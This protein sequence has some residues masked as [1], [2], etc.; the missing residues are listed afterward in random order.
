MKKNSLKETH[1][2]KSIADNLSGLLEINNLNSNQLANLLGIPMMTVRRLLSGETEDPRI[3][4]LKIISDYFGVSV[5]V[6]VGNNSQNLLM[7]S[8]KVAS[9]LVP[10]IS[11]DSLSTS[12]NIREIDFKTLTE[13]QSISLNEQDTISKST[14]ALESKPSM[15]PRF[16]NG[17][18]FIIDPE[19]MP[20][21]GDI[22]LVK[23]KLNNNVTLRELV[24]DPPVWQLLALTANSKP[25]DFQESEHEIVG[26]N[27]LTLLYSNKFNG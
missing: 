10:K 3:S 26:V 16:P 6:L 18:I 21:D 14:F 24:I 22:V 4:T 23:I 7:P 17:S 15:Y 27:I 12:K 25:I 9:Y 5:D 19:V 2:Q 8:K 20:A 13:W 11:W 1:S